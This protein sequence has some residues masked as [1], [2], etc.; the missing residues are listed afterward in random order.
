MRI[1][2]LA[3]LVDRRGVDH[4]A[5]EARVTSNENMRARV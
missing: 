3:R 2:E 5:L 4:P 1:D